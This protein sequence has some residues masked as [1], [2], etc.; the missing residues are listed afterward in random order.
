MMLIGRIQIE[1]LH[2]MNQNS[3][4]IENILNQV[5]QKWARVKEKLDE[6][7]ASLERK[8]L[9]RR[10][11]EELATLRDVYEGYN[12]YISQAEPLGTD[13]QKLNLQL[14]TNRVTSFVNMLFVKKKTKKPSL[15]TRISFTGQTQR[16]ELVRAAFEQSERAEHTIR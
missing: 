14:E 10:A 6:M 7:G 1:Q 3:N 5:A 12:R 9:T 2:N 11:H 8:V 16:H 15:F 13:E 4:D